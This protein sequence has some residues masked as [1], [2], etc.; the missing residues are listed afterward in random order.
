MYFSLL[1]C[2]IG[3]TFKNCFAE[4]DIMKEKL[5]LNSIYSTFKCLI[6]KTDIDHMLLYCVDQFTY[7]QVELYY[8][9]IN[10]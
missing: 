9:L 8:N 7:P 5:T 4:I 10:K 1:I 3:K 2:E 6:L